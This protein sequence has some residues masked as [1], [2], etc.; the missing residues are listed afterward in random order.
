MRVLD[1]HNLESVG[2][3]DISNSQDSD[4]DVVDSSQ[5]RE[6]PRPK[7]TIKIIPAS[8]SSVRVFVW[9]SETGQSVAISIREGWTLENM[10]SA[11]TEKLMSK[12]PYKHVYYK[13]NNSEILHMEDIREN[14]ELLLSTGPKNGV[15]HETH[16]L[17]SDEALKS[18]KTVNRLSTHK[19]RA[20]SVVP[21]LEEIKEEKYTKRLSQKSLV[22][23]DSDRS[24]DGQRVIEKNVIAYNE[25]VSTVI[26]ESHLERSKSLINLKTEAPETVEP[27]KNTKAEKES[28]SIHSSESNLST[29]EYTDEDDDEDYKFIRRQYNKLGKNTMFDLEEEDTKG[30]IDPILIS[31]REVYKRMTAEEKQDLMDV[32]VDEDGD[33]KSGTF[34]ALV[35][36]LISHLQDPEFI[37]AFLLTYDVFID[38]ISLLKSL[39]LLFR[40]PLSK[41]SCPSGGLSFSSESSESESFRNGSPSGD[42]AMGRKI[43]VIQFRLVN[44]ICEWVK[45][46]YE[47]LRMEE[48]FVTLYNRFKTYISKMKR[49][50]I[51][52]LSERLVK[53]WKDARKARY[54]IKRNLQISKPSKTESL[55]KT[56]YNGI[57]NVPP[58]ELARQLT[59]MEQD[60]FG[61]VHLSEYVSFL[62][63]EADK[64]P[65]LNHM[66]KR[67]NRISFWVA[68]LILDR[69]LCSSNKQRAQVISHLTL[70]MEELR[71][72]RNFSSM[73][74]IFSALNLGCVSRLNKTWSHVGQKTKNLIKDVGRMFE[75]NYKE[76]R[77][78]IEISD[79][80]C[81]PIQEV[82]FRDLTFIE[83]TVDIFENG[84]INFEKMFLLGRTYKLLKKFQSTQYEFK[85]NNDIYA[86][87]LSYDILDDNELY[88]ESF[89]IEPMEESKN[90]DKKK[91]KKEKKSSSKK[92]LI[93]SNSKTPVVA[94]WSPLK[95]K[96]FI[97]T[98]QIPEGLLD[99]VIFQQFSRHMSALFVTEMLDFCAA[100]VDTWYPLN[101]EDESKENATCIKEASR[102][103]YAEYISEVSNRALSLDGP[104]VKRLKDKLLATQE[105][106]HRSLF[107]EITY[108]VVSQIKTH[109]TIGFKPSK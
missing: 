13:R 5:N 84:W 73:L 4:S 53:A 12:K 24:L 72:L 7:E 15:I 71:K 57:L 8:T 93:S 88:Q 20:P 21:I 26:Y 37:E 33:V 98:Y 108:Q 39:I 43:F 1:Q 23:G 102:K 77:I 31:D 101:F 30:E 10:L 105:M 85:S 103:L 75:N 34:R 76:Y 35:R 94:S 56:V 49:T 61:R 50:K 11:A 2:E 69:K 18:P 96:E 92:L 80:P 109:F 14:D 91:A 62:S 99:P 41:E 107:D 47:S 95:S 22:R 68:T 55:S 90:K 104:S 59:V 63:K 65:H 27:L 106:P 46:R 86:W 83:E 87:A 16:S 54:N 52:S 40:S 58:V 6:S 42:V 29:I 9:D 36:R 32:E 48:D 60:L 66:I 78:I 74:Q 3:K 81:I 44:I 28:E 45:L 25:E 79:P 38:H 67:F 97:T 100:I 82:I 89:Q 17:S 70:V 51:R 19:S 64:S